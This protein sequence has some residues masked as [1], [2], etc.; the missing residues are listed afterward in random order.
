M[1]DKVE[2][3]EKVAKTTEKKT[4]SESEK[5]VK[6]ISES[7]KTEKKARSQV[8]NNNAK[9]GPRNGKHEKLDDTAVEKEFLAFIAKMRSKYPGNGLAYQMNNYPEVSRLVEWGKY[10]QTK[11]ILYLAN[12]ILA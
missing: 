11:T 2:S 8:K 10:C 6:S 12:T 1:S 3:P 7:E 5:K 4:F 9:N